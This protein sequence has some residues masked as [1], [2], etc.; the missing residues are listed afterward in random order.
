MF[1]KKF[2]HLTFIFDFDGTLVHSNQNKKDQFI[3][4]CS[5]QIE[6]EYMKTLIEK[7]EL[8]R[9]EI[10]ELFA[11]KF[12]LQNIRSLENEINFKLETI[13]LKSDLRVGS[14]KTLDLLSK[15]N[16]NWHINSATPTNSL[17]K[18][19]KHH[20]PFLKSTNLV[21][22]AELNKLKTLNKIKKRNNLKLN[23]MIFIGDGYDDFEAANLFKC[24]FIPVEGGT[25]EKRYPKSINILK[26]IYDIFSNV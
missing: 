1:I 5:N 8:T 11:K 25:F 20:F 10:I 18:S 26:D 12:G 6:I 22:G 15:S 21:I 19:V 23:N 17:L 7:P 2:S 14:Y 24:K 9:K 3:S 13:V 4:L 16:I